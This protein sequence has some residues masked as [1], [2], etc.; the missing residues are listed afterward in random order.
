MKTLIDTNAYSAFMSGEKKIRT[1]LETAEEVFVPAVVLGELYSGFHMGNYTDRNIH[2]LELF[3]SKPGIHCL[4]IT[5][6]IAERYGI[7][8]KAL[9]GRG[10]PIPTNDIWISASVLETGAK[11]LTRDRHFE[12]VPGVL[13]VP[14]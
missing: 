8:V 6:Q 14:F 7:L 12:A 13:V 4:D 1:I 10:T 5:K 2:E 11:L 3:L 9:K